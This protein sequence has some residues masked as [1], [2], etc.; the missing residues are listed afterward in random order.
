MGKT[1]GVAG[2]WEAET[3]IVLRK[4]SYHPKKCAK[5]TCAPHTSYQN[6]KQKCIHK[7]QSHTYNLS[8]IGIRQQTCQNN[9]TKTTTDDRINKK[10]YTFITAHTEVNSCNATCT[11]FSMRKGMASDKK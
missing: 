4:L 11:S 8:L 6:V 10:N 3:I 2:K 5:T 9:D 7:H 1:G